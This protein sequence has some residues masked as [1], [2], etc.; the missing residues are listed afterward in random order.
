MT[1]SVKPAFSRAKLTLWR[2]SGRTVSAEQEPRLA[3]DPLPSLSLNLPAHPLSLNSTVLNTVPQ[4]SRAL[5][6]HRK[7][8]S[9]KAT[10][11]ATALPHKTLWL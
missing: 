8:K 6:S 4:S 7:D 9:P 11:A 2:D 1:I 10:S 5:P 3:T